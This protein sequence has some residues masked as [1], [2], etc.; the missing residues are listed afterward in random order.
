MNEKSSEKRILFVGLNTVDLQFFVNHYPGPNTKT[1]AHHN[2]VITGGPATNAAIACAWLGSS[3]DLYTPVGRHSLSSFILEDISRYQIRILDP[4]AGF[5]SQP[6]FASIITSQ[7]NGERT[8]FSYHPDHKV[9]INHDLNFNLN[10]YSLVLFDGFHPELAIYLARE[11]NQKGIACVLDGGSWKPGL[12]ELLK[13]IQIAICSNDFRVPEREG[14]PE[15]FEFLHEK[16][17]EMA[18]I[19]R[20]DESILYSDKQMQDEIMVKPVSVKDTLGAGD[21]FH[22]AFCHYYAAGHTFTSSLEQASYI[23]GKSC[24]CLGTRAWMKV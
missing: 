3:V 16:G 8:I 2:E 22:G 20:G 14:S 11:A 19:T 1:K 5:E 23:A 18:A 17:V 12:E 21:I 4:I 9:V 6:V 15:I 7:H 13:Y 24:K 10:D